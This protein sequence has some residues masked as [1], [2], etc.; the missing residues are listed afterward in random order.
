MKYGGGP[1]LDLG[2]L[3]T[4]KHAFLMSLRLEAQTV[5]VTLLT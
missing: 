1:N 4:R 5:T 3:S 2:E